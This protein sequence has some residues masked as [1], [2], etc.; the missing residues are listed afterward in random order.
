[1][2]QNVN[3]N[4]DASTLNSGEINKMSTEVNNKLD[5]GEINK[6]LNILNTDAIHPPITD[7]I[8]L[9]KAHSGEQVTLIDYN[10]TLEKPQQISERSQQDVKLND[11]A[12]QHTDDTSLNQNEPK[13]PLP[14]QEDPINIDGGA[15]THVYGNMFLEENSTLKPDII[16]FDNHTTRK[17]G[18]PIESYITTTAN[19]KGTKILLHVNQEFSNNPSKVPTTILSDLLSPIH[20][21]EQHNNMKINQSSIN[22]AKDKYKRKSYQ[23]KIHPNRPSGNNFKDI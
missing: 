7:T 19:H 16:N 6:S 23:K 1:M 10:T 12:E 8:T 22:M 14:N 20:V 18:L 2:H 4:Q 13:V 3:V 15:D 9:N 21:T 11:D 5:L 17:K